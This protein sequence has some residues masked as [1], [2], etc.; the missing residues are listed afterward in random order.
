MHLARTALLA[1]VLCTNSAIAQE[2]NPYNGTWRAEFETKKG[3]DMEGTIVIK[4]QGGSWDMLGKANN[5]PCV[6]RA[7]PIT[8]QQATAESLVFKI[9]RAETLAGCKDGTVK[10]RRVDDKTLE[11]EFEKV[12]PIK[13]IRQ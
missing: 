6:G 10:L 3:S 5:N 1:A 4:D 2:P 8:V 11:G 7:Y 9:N 12:R 13:L